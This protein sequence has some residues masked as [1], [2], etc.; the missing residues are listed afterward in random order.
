MGLINDVFFMFFLCFAGGG[1]IG[2]AQFS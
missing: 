1:D 2:K